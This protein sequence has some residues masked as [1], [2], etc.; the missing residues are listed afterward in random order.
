MAKLP[1]IDLRAQA[2]DN[3]PARKA[4]AITKDDSNPIPHPSGEATTRG[5]LVGTAGDLKLLFQDD[6]VAVTVKSLAAG[7]VYPF[8][9][10]QVYNT[11][12]TASDIIGL[13]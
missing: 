5:I 11:G 12:S 6:T 3:V 2:K 9:V 8:S 13:Y 4:I 1:L 7:V 10:K